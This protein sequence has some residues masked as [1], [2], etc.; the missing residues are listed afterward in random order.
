MNDTFD[1][2]NQPSQAMH[3]YRKAFLRNDG[4]RYNAFLKKVLE[5]AEKLAAISK[6]NDYKIYNTFKTLNKEYTDIVKKYLDSQS[7]DEALLCRKAIVDCKTLMI[8]ILE[9][10]DEKQRKKAMK[11]YDDTLNSFIKQYDAIRAYDEGGASG[12]Q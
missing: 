4:E 1:Y 2:S 6:D 11:N 12:T 5:Q 7:E 8:D 9:A 3:R 10:K